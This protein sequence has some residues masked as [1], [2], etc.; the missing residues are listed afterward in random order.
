V[1]PD[2]ASG[3][4]R[5]ELTYEALTRGWDRLRTWLDQRARFRDA[6]RFWAEHGR[7]RGALLGENLLSD[8][9]APADR[10]PLEEEFIRASE[11]AV[12]RQKDDELARLRELATANRRRIFWLYASAALLVSLL[13]A[14]L[15]ALVQYDRAHNRQEQ[16]TSAA[17]ELAVREGEERT[18][19]FV[20]NT[21][22]QEEMENRKKAQ[23][24][25]V[26]ELEHRLKVQEQMAT[27]T[28][29]LQM[30][31]SEPPP[32]EQKKKGSVPDWRVNLWTNGQPLRIRFLDGEPSLQETAA[33][34]AQ[35]WTEGTG[36]R[37]VVTDDPNAEIRVTFAGPGTHSM[38]GTQ[39]L[40]VPRNQSTMTL[41]F[42]RLSLPESEIARITLHEF[43]HVLGLI[44]EHQNPKSKLVWDEERLERY[45]RPLL[46][47]GLTREQVLQQV[48]AEPDPAGI[49]RDF[50]PTSVMIF[51]YPK[52]VF[53]SGWDPRMERLSTNLSE[54]D[55]EFARL[56]YPPLP[57]AVEL[58]PGPALQRRFDKPRQ[59]DRFDVTVPEGKPH[60]LAV[61]GPLELGVVVLDPKDQ[62]VARFTV[63]PKADPAATPALKPGR[64]TV[65]VQPVWC[66]GSQ[67][68]SIGLTPAE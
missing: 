34:Y 51:R 43:G 6:A 13:I 45:L 31:G 26:D 55:R 64:Y 19:L 12:A 46:P 9:P 40:S 29:R 32:P 30:S 16:L 23:K 36:L 53:K 52:E 8:V 28:Q 33:K 67:T 50:D 56:L 41:G 1:A 11:T 57:Q 15:V 68:Y 27:I 54:S 49:Y 66:D 25:Q 2:V 38:Q 10:T 22:L 5:L 20:L 24:E 59:T 39:A 7:D 47:P 3:G 62:L 4:D 42:N 21:K 35:R 63:K 18:R 17:N 60:R 61:N 44:H 14:A 48:K 65:C 58:R 37:F